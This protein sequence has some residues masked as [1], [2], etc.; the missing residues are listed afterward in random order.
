MRDGSERER[1]ISRVATWNVNYRGPG[2]SARQGAYLRPFE[3]DV[4]ML[5]EV[6]PR[7]LPA[8]IEEAG[9]DWAV[10]AADLRVSPPNEGSGRRRVSAIAGRGARPRTAKLFT[11]V[12]LPE[13]L[14][15]AELVDAEGPVTVVSYHG[16]PGVSWGKVKVDH[17][18]ALARWLDTVEGTVIVGADANTPEVDHPDPKLARTHWFTGN[19][20]LDPGE[21]GDDEMFGTAPSHHLR[22]A[23]RSWL[24]A[25]PDEMERIRELRPEGPLAVTHRTGKRRATA[26]TPR[27]F[28]HLWLS[29]DLQVASI[30]HDYDGAVAAGSDHALVVA[31]LRR[32]PSHGPGS[33]GVTHPESGASTNTGGRWMSRS[34]PRGCTPRR[35]S[36]CQSLQHQR[37]P[38]LVGLGLP[39]WCASTTRTESP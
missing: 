7:T 18:L 17:A 32:D 39:G 16:P 5:Q 22:D 1:V 9:L 25:N 4:V 26:G 15:V 2:V 30:S 38:R 37:V 36:V 21:P 13:R 31:E 28:D 12:R 24:D 8:L 10:T 29:P 3:L 11:H 14:I 23:F 33:C 35:T 6:N 20:R 34:R 19:P 27:R